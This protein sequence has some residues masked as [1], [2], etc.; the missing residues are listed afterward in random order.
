MEN[1]TT[2]PAWLT[3]RQQEARD[4]FGALPWP[5]ESI[6][7][8]K[9]TSLSAFDA[10]RYTPA[11]PVITVDADHGDGVRVFPLS[12]ADEGFAKD[13]LGRATVP[14]HEAKFATWNA[15][16]A[17]PLVIHVPRGVASTTPVRIGPHISH[18][19]DVIFPHLIILAEEGA[20]VTVVD[21][22]A[23]PPTTRGDAA[24]VANVEIHAEQ[25]ATVN[26]IS[27][28]D[29]PQTVFHF[30]LL[31]AF[32][33]RDATVRTLV[34]SIGA[35]LSRTV[36]RAI[37]DGQAAHAELLGVSFGD[38]EQHID[39]RTL[40]LHRA[41]HTTSDLYYKGALK[42]RAR[43]VYSGLVD[44]DK[45]GLQADAQQAN[46]NLMLSDHA[47][48]DATPFLEIKTSEVARATHAVSVG[49]P[50]N[51]VLF[52]LLSRGLDPALAERLFVKGFFQEVID[53]VRDETV[54]KTLEA[55]VELELDLEDDA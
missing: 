31:Q 26:Y 36:N 50:D 46:R 47:H 25:N 6:E 4:R 40:Q 38:H 42:G 39:N 17:D 23:D 12:Q 48:A 5:D 24:C 22:Y 1:E 52:Y 53:R 28:Q 32:A 10:E 35:R 14:D 16:Y 7:E 3:A 33:G 29:H 13:L 51:E 43:S 27:V 49:R 15:G 54:R 9:H 19:G 37:L 11:A 41:P 44:L 2:I 34:A 55:A 8:W 18:N 21:G 20:Q 45:D 30:A